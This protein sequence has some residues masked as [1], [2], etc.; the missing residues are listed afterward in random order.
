MAFL[1]VKITESRPRDIPRDV[2]RHILRRAHQE[3]G[4]VW[5]KEILPEHFKPGARAKYRHRL[6]RLRY[7]RRK[8]Q[9]IGRAWAPSN[10]VVVEGPQPTDN[11]L[12]GAM[13][14]ELKRQRTVRAFP[15]RVTVTMF[16][17]RYMTM[18]A[19]TGDAARAVQEGW[20]YGRGREFSKRYSGNQ[21]DKRKEITTVTIAERRRLAAV[22]EKSVADQLA[23]YRAPKTT[24]I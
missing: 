19:F 7:D 11:I 18:R 8:S 3:V 6:R 12:S 17:P 13:Q 10:P 9:R 20:T 14:R 21:P 24:E 22:L 4:D 1:R 16:G 23:A 2:W 15:T 5:H